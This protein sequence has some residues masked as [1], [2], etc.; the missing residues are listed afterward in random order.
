MNHSFNVNEY[1]APPAHLPLSS[2]NS[3]TKHTQTAP[4]VEAPQNL[5]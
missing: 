3:L 1:A 4:P 5:E 2:L